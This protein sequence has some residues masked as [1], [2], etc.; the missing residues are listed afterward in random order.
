MKFEYVLMGKF[1]TDKLENR[2]GLYRRMSGCNYN[3][4]V[5]QVLESE[6]KLKIMNILKLSSANSTH[7]I[8]HIF[9]SLTEPD[10]HTPSK[11]DSFPGL[12]DDI[13]HLDV[14]NNDI[15]I[16]V[17]ISGY[18]AFSVGKRLKCINCSCRLTTEQDLD[19]EIDPNSTQ[20]LM[21]INR[22]GLKWP[23]QFT[24]TLCTNTFLIF[25][26]ILAKFEGTF[27]LSGN[28]RATLLNLSLA[29]NSDSL[30]QEIC[31]CNRTMENIRT[32]C[33]RTMSNILLNNYSKNLNDNLRLKRNK[34]RKLATLSK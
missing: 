31:S 7:K 26:Q 13:M 11:F 6:K 15:S 34:K 28:Q 17:Y 8:S 33:I 23:S 29:Y 3:V 18:V 30:Y 24:L 4:S 2:F 14:S 20:Y 12:L 9:D 21:L 1:Q 25:Q 19:V 10:E 16:L 27:L 32:Q 5:A 22:G